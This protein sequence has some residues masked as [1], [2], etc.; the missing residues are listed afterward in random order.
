MV[1]LGYICD[2]A[3]ISSCVFN[4]PIDNF[5]RPHY[6]RLVI[7]ALA[8]P[9]HIAT[10][11]VFISVFIRIKEQ[12]LDPRML[13][14]V[15]VLAFLIGY[16]FWEVLS[17]PREQRTRACHIF[18]VVR[19]L[20]TTNRYQ[21][22]QIVNSGLPCAVGSITC[23]SDFD[24]SDLF[25]FHMG[26]CGIPISLAHSPCRLHLAEPSRDE[27]T[28]WLNRSLSPDAHCENKSLTSVLSMNAAISSSVVLAS[29]LDSNLAVF[30]LVLFAVQCFALFP[31][32]RRKLQVGWESDVANY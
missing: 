18:P 12:S 25:G 15:V 17:P 11:F 16:I 32:L 5:E 19:V 30:A 9:Q 2:L 21:S 29:R 20:N 8:I 23:S 28:V 4:T 7:A 6:G 14:W 3:G 1:Q 13:I 27:R 31:I 24:G 22:D 10:I 26:T